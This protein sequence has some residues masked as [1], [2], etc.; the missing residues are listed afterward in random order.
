MQS[1]ARD[2]TLRPRRTS[3]FRESALFRD[4]SQHSARP[5]LKV[6]FRSKNDI[7]DSPVPDDDLEWD[8]IQEDDTEDLPD[9]T[10]TQMAPPS[11]TRALIHRTALL[12]FVLAVVLTIAQI[13]PFTKHGRPLFG[14]FGSPFT[15]PIQE[16]SLSKRADDPTDYCKRWSQQSAI[17]N[18]TLY[19]YGGRKTTAQGQKSNTW[20]K[21]ID[22]FTIELLLIGLTQTTTSSSSTSQRPGPYPLLLPPVSPNHPALL[23][24]QMATSGTPIPHYT[25][26]AE[27]F[28]ITQ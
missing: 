28:Q 1:L 12:A 5:A 7:F 10:I 16:L 15:A 19:L 26:T 6:R 24:W 11:P 21:S 22:R 4:E 18:G 3:A 17:V 23:P 9:T 2:G 14:A 8:D 27:N 20:S 25:C 13:T